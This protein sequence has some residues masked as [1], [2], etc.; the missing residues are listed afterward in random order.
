MTDEELMPRVAGGD[1]KA[2]AELVERHRSRAMRLAYGVSRN[3]TE[4]E[5]FVQEAFMR[6]WTKAGSWDARD[7]ARFSAWLARITINLAIDKKRKM[8]EEQLDETYPIADDSVGSEDMLHGREIGQRISRA[9]DKLPER[10]RIAFA[11]CQID[12]MSNA[13]AANSLGVTVGALELLLV[14]ARKAVRLE[15]ADLIEAMQ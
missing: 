11:L 1:E 12:R 8:R 6:V 4:A 15:L 13:E 14:R 5:D 9:L 3:R 7:G 2:F 10:Q